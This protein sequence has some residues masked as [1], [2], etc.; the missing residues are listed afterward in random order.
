MQ[1]SYDE[2]IDFAQRLLFEASV[3]ADEARQIA[4]SLVESNLRGHES[5][6]VVRIPDYVAQIRTGEL[7]PAAELRILRST[8]AII[9]A[10]AGFGFGQIQCAKLIDLLVEKAREVGIACGTL[11]NCGH[12][13]R[14][15]EW[16][17]R[18]AHCGLAG[19]MTVNDNGVLTC[20]APPGGIEPR[21]STNPLAFGIPI[22]SETLVL[23]MSTSVVANG[24]IRVAQLAGRTCPP[25]WLQDAKGNPTTDPNTR[26][27]D[28]PGTILPI[29]GDQGYKGFGLGIVLDILS[30]GLAGG[31]CPPAP[32]EATLTN[33]ALFAVWDPDQFVGRGHFE[34]QAACLIEAVRGTTLKPG[35]AEIRLPG[36]QSRALAEARRAKG[37]PLDDGTWRSLVELAGELGVELPNAPEQES[38]P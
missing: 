33:N 20:V 31:F 35:A 18:I 11:V 22:G 28:P 13:G 8:A 2:L 12:V 30:A 3:R 21:I 9:V 6:G 29:G 7:V 32:S 37:V 24:K 17:E 36:D 10:D 1:L 27:A 23:D 4:S 25:G 38:K 5:H 16:V 15:G 34:Q 19:F 14:L 26:F